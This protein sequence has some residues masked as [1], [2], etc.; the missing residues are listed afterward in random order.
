[1]KRPTLRLPEISPALRKELL[2][3][4]SF[5]IGLVVCATSIA[6]VYFPAGLFTLGLELCGVP[7]WAIKTG[8]AK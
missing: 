8:V 7:F 3:T 6:L 5:A 2:V 1:M 4:G